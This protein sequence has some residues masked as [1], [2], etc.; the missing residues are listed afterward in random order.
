MTDVS[1]EN[2]GTAGPCV[3]PKYAV[4]GFA[5]IPAGDITGLPSSVP[6]DSLAPVAAVPK[7]PSELGATDIGEMS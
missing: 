6:G 4:Q 5:V 2:L 7:V 3:S 1:T